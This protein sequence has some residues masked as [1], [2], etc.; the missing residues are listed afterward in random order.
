MKYK[1]S[2]LAFGLLLV[3]AMVFLSACPSPTPQATQAVS[4]PTKAP[5]E[6]P[7]PIGWSAPKSG[8]HAILGEWD[9]R[10]ILL[11]EARKLL[12]HQYERGI[13]EH[14]ERR[15]SAWSRS[16][17]LHRHCRCLLSSRRRSVTVLLRP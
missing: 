12:E 16:S 8:T 11:A 6:G 2:K 10:G 15:S 7:I 17:A 13:L 4:E 14:L 3:V 5:E 1:V 9:E